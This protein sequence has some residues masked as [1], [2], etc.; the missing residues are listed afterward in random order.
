MK[1]CTARI[2]SEDLVDYLRSLI[3]RY[4]CVS[5][6]FSNCLCFA[7]ATLPTAFTISN[8]EVTCMNFSV[9]NDSVYFRLGLS[10]IVGA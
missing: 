2:Q 1:I 6:V 5:G 9:L 3:Q 10:Q 4:L 8:I 7:K